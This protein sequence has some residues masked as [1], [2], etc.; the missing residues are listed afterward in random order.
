MESTV[1]M[2]LC[3]KLNIMF[4]KVLIGYLK[5]CYYDAYVV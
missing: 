1:Q 4:E 3:A 2:L 5:K